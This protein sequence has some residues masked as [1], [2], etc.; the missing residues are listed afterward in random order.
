MRH[1]HAGFVSGA[2]L[3]VIRKDKLSAD[4]DW[5]DILNRLSHFVIDSDIG[6]NRGIEP[7]LCVFE[8]ILCRGLPTLPSLYVE[9]QLARLTGLFTC[10]PKGNKSVS[11]FECGIKSDTPE[12]IFS[13]LEIALCVAAP[14]GQ[15]A[16]SPGFEFP[17]FGSG[18]ISDAFESKAEEQFWK[19][20]LSQILGTGG[21][22]LALRQR[23]LDTVIG[24]EFQEQRADIAVQFPGCKELNPKGIIFEVD[25]PHHSNMAMQ[26]GDARRDEAS[27]KRGWA[28]TYRHQLWKRTRATDPIPEKHPGIAKVIKH[29]YLIRANE[30]IKKPLVSSDEGRRALYLAL[31][32]MAVARI[33][34]VILELMRGGI[35]TLDAVEWNLA[36]LERDGLRGCGKVAAEDFRIWMDNLI[37]IYHP[38]RKVPVINVHEIAQNDT[39]VSVPLNIDVLLDVSVQQRYGV[40]L[41]EPP[42]V[43]S[44][45]GVPKVVIRSGYFN[46]EP[47]HAFSFADSVTP[48]IKGSK[49]EE[50]LTFFLQ[51]IFRK[52]AFRDKQTDIIIRA[53]YGESVIAL[54]PTGAG[55]SIT[56]QL[57]AIL[58]NGIVIVVDP[59]KSLM[60]DQVDNLSALCISSAFISS[61]N[62]DAKERRHNIELMRRGCLKFVFVSP[63]RLVIQEFRDALE[64]ISKEGVVHFA[65]A[66]IDEAH[67]VS[68]W[69]HDFRIAYLRLGIN[70]R[71]FCVT[72]RNELPLLA[73]TGTASLDV[74]EDVAIELEY[75]KN[76][77]ITVKPDS[78]KRDNLKF[79]VVP[80]NPEPDISPSQLKNE[81]KVRET[82]G[83]AKLASLPAILE[84]M[85]QD[86][87]GLKMVDFLSADKGSG[88]IF[89]PH[90]TNFHGVEEVYSQLKSNFNSKAETF[91]IFHGSPDEGRITTGF[92][93]IKIQNDFKKGSVKVLA[94]T[95]AFGMGIDKPDIRFTLHFNIPPSLESFYQEAGRAGRDGN[96]SLCWVLYAGTPMPGHSSHSLDYSLNHSFYSNSFPGADL[97]EAKV[98]EILDENRVPGR[99]VLRKIEESLL[100]N[101]ETEYR[102]SLWHPEN[103]VHYRVYI[104]H[105]EFPKAKVY[106]DITAH[107]QVVCEVKFPFPNHEDVCRI[108][109]GWIDENRPEGILIRD[110]LSKDQSLTVVERHK[111]IEELL[112]EGQNRQKIC[113]SFDNGYLEE[114]ANRIDGA[115]LPM[116]RDSFKFVHDPDT[117]IGKLSDKLR[118][119]KKVITQSDVT[120]LQKIFRKIRQSEHTFKAIYRLTVLGAAKDYVVDYAT[121]TIIAELD[122]LPDGQ[123]LE[124]LCEYVCR[125]APQDA[126]KYLEIAKKSQKKT[127]LRQCIH[128][129][130]QFVYDRI[131]KQRV[132]AMEAMERAT[133]K[134]MED[135]TAL[136][137]TVTDYFDSPYIPILRPYLNEYTSDLVF[138]ICNDTG[139]GRAKLFNLL[140]A[141]DRLLE[142]NPNNAAFHAMRAYAYTFLDYGDDVVLSEIEKTLACFESE[143]QWDRKEN[144][145]F[146]M[147]LRAFI[148]AINHQ[149]AR[150][151]EAAILDDHASVLRKFNTKKENIDSL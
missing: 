118:K 39:T 38:K 73:L 36:V 148:R 66:V 4:L 30:N 24:E 78:M 103:S 72:R 82:V 75:K 77:D 62:K 51:N 29:P 99:S 115:N 18:E 96:E 111:G 74:L 128:A 27:K 6:R 122:S 124:R 17:D 135:P 150:P 57:S 120:W 83:K 34:R 68:E 134:G 87:T 141:S 37:A 23:S 104:N 19:G 49:L 116:V 98:N 88:L 71:R 28:E 26:Q 108:V 81:F 140:G 138:E 79:R 47:D 109:K 21:M 8:N 33:Q 137:E 63:E 35:L 123:Y 107:D 119:D 86:M 129:L 70:A 67:C 121:K 102:V 133:V 56:Y 69:G 131:A 12:S 136:A 146:L 10:N 11:A 52:K 60:K 105:P 100:E 127:E 2:L 89:C 95:K 54:L 113:L 40:S 91:G 145:H 31:F 20:P 144:L 3:N 101:T 43:L 142:Q 42:C 53:L 117:F 46:A 61:M 58:Q 130:I 143:L 22:Q 64:S 44:M 106:V 126:E 15:L 97:E 114:I 48:E 25:G 59:I 94:C 112:N 149:K 55:K 41:P 13:L 147:R 50:H 45:S 5:A 85:T 84:N 90:A 125:Y 92:D 76:T 93:P 9:K 139:A 132:A 151:Y 14:Q 80:L 16:P 1:L 7:V 32:P 65:F 110:W